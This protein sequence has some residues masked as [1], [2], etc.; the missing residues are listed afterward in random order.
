MNVQRRRCGRRLFDVSRGRWRRARVGSATHSLHEPG[1]RRG[2]RIAGELHR[3]QVVA[4]GD[5]GAAVW[6][7]PPRAAVPSKRRTRRAAR[8]ALER[9][10]GQDVAAYGRLTAPGMWPATGSIGSTSPRKRSGARAST[11]KRSCV[12]QARENVL[13]A[14]PSA[15]SRRSRTSPDARRGTSALTGRAARAPTCEAAVE[16]RDRVVAEPAQHPPQPRRIHR[17]A[18]IVGDDLRCRRRCR[19]GRRVAAASSG[20]GSGWRPLRPVFGADRSRSMWAKRAPGMCPARYWFRPSLRLRQVVPHVD[21]DE[22]DRRDAR[23]ARRCRSA[24][25]TS[26]RCHASRRRGHRGQRW[27][28]GQS[29][30]SQSLADWPA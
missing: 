8:R 23:R 26:H 1:R 4:R 17:V 6:T 13:H 9:A 20:E 24:C 11:K 16:H 15:A 21:D 19:G 12:R 22:P 3:Q 28:W 2:R 27:H 18:L 5:A 25:G 10:V 30:C 29:R 14:R 7:I